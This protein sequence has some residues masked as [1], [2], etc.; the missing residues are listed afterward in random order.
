MMDNGS[1]SATLE[2]LARWM[3]Q[4]H[5]CPICHYKR[6]SGHGFLDSLLYESVNDFGLR[7]QL[8]QSLGFCALHSREM[9][10]FPGAKLG[11][12]IL[13]QS[14]LKEALRRIEV[15]KPASRRSL[16]GGRG[17]RGGDPSKH[18]SCPICLH[19]REAEQRALEE[20]LS[21]W[22]GAWAA[23]LEKAGGLCYNHLT[24]ALRLSAN[25]TTSRQLKALHQRLWRA[26]V[27]HLDEFIR[28]QDYR[29]RH[30][31]IQDE[32]REAIQRAVRILTGE[33]DAPDVQHLH[34]SS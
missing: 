11:A 5:G 4:A 12:A 7:Q 2:A 21:H 18:K 16:L 28:K 22:D 3:D 1:S 26:L 23:S 10:L 20:L 29:F 15:S 6:M 32:E 33:D 31:P 24:Q 14:M 34:R 30:E 19:E 8:T 17:R 27:A 13:E 9:L 25:E